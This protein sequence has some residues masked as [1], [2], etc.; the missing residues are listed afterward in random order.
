M[1]LFC[2]VTHRRTDTRHDA[3]IVR[4][5]SKWPSDPSL[6]APVNK[7][8]GSR[9]LRYLTLQGLCKVVEADPGLPLKVACPLVARTFPLS[10][11]FTR[12][13]TSF[14]TFVITPINYLIDLVIASRSNM[15]YGRFHGEQWRQL[16]HVAINYLH[17]E[18]YS[19]SLIQNMP[20]ICYYNVT[21]IVVRQRT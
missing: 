2:L 3:F 14:I 12:R 9:C 16:H 20:I 19:Q 18:S 21:E 11:S 10:R 5:L 7:D 13:R 17:S 4:P 6:I 15:K 1:N 8:L